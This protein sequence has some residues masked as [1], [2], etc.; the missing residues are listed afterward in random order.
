MIVPDSELRRRTAPPQPRHAHAR[1]FRGLLNKLT[2][3][4][5]L[6]KNYRYIGQAF[7]P[8]GQHSVKA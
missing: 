6:T 5:W 3:R 8:I 7:D 4:L 1:L 2:S